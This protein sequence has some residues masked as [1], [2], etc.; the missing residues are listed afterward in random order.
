MYLRPLNRRPQAL[1]NFFPG[2]EICFSQ[3]NHKLLATNTGRQIYAARAGLQDFRE[4]AQHFV[5]GLMSITIIDRLEVI[6]V[7]YQQTEVPAVATLTI[8]LALQLT[9][10]TAPVCQSAQVIGKCGF[11][12]SVQI[13]LEVQQ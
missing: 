7:E 5:P 1:G 2:F 13:V 11:L 4:P 12:A 8:D 6:D 3:E 9:F 10:K